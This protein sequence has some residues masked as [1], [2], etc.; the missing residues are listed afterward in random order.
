[1]SS[2]VVQGIA[3]IFNALFDGFLKIFSVVAETISKIF[4]CGSLRIS[5]MF[6]LVVDGI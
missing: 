3:A 4:L 2:V 6:Y 5:T 1:M